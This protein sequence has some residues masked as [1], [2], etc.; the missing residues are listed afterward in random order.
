MNLTGT[1]G[2]RI[3][4]HDLRDTF[5]THLISE[6]VNVKTVPYLLGHANAAMPL[7]AYTSNTPAGMESAA[8][9]LEGLAK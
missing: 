7:N 9:A 1:A 5:A 3:T 4:F 8:T 6:G 2:K